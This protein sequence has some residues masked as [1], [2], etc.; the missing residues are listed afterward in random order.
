[1]NKHFDMKT[2]PWWIKLEGLSYDEQQAV[3]EFLKVKTGACL[4]AH[5]VTQYYTNYV[6]GAVSE[7]TNVMHGSTYLDE[8]S[9]EFEIVLQFKQ[10]TV[11]AD[12]TYPRAKPTPTQLKIA[13][14]EKV[15]QDAQEKLS[16]LKAIQGVK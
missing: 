7:V 8:K 9:P 14:L 12:V 15:M 11:V 2:K 6:A 4:A 3:R 13:E 16:A 1:M 5:G 10:E